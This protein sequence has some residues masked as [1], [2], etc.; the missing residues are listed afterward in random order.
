M[1]PKGPGNRVGRYTGIKGQSKRKWKL[2][3]VKFPRRYDR[4]ACDAC[5]P[6]LAY[7]SP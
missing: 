6:A 3:S 1:S 2:L 4:E 5:E 7:G